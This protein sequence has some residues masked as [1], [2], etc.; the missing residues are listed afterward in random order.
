MQLPP[1][2]TTYDPS[3]CFQSLCCP[4]LGQC[5]MQPAQNQLPVPSSSSLTAGLGKA[6]FRKPLLSASAVQNKASGTTDR[7]IKQQAVKPVWLHNPH[8]EGAVV[9]NRAQW[10][11]AGEGGPVWPVVVDPHVGRHLRPH[12]S[13]GV[14]FLY[15][16]IMGL[17]EANRQAQPD[18]LPWLWT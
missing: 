8:A 5:F 9:L 2:R 17:K 1:T 15:E 16:C 3:H 14:Q 11:Q 12:Q 10:Q 6:G 18:F 7:S 13:Q 4:R